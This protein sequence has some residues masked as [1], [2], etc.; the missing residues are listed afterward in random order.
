[1]SW[2]IEIAGPAQRD[3]RRLD[4]Q[5]ARRVLAAIDRLAREEYGDI[6]L[7][8]GTPGRWRLRVGD[9]RVVYWYDRPNRTIVITRVLPRGRA[10]RDRSGSGPYLID[11]GGPPMRGAG[12]H[13]EH[14]ACDPSTGATMFV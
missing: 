10:Y 11:P 4:R 5:V 2:A 9:W 14:A 12:E 7:L 8:H 3:L 1:L 13:G 6:K